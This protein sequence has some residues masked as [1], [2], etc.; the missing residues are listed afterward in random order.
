MPR[1]NVAAS[2]SFPVWI[3]VGIAGAILNAIAYQDWQPFVVVL[4]LYGAA[5]AVLY[6]TPLGGVVERRTFTAC[7]LTAWF[8]AGIAALYLQ[9]AQ[10][11]DQLND[12]EDFY[13]LASDP[14][15]APL[16]LA[17]FTQ[18][19][20]GAGA[21]VLWR[22][23]Y[24]F[25]A[26]LGLE[27]GRY[28]GITLNSLAVA[29]NGVVA[30]KICVEL[31]GYDQR[32]LRRLTVLLATCGLYGLFASIHLRDALVLLSVTVLTYVWVRFLRRSGVGNGV[33]VATATVLGLV[34]FPLLRGQF[35]FVPIATTLAGITAV[36][37]FDPPASR[38][39]VAFVGVALFGIV[40][41]VNLLIRYQ[42]DLLWVLTVTPQQYAE[43]AARVQGSLGYALIVGAPFPLNIVLKSVYQFVAPIP[44]WTGFQLQSAYLLFK[45]VAAVYFYFTIPLVVLAIVR[46]VR[47]KSWRTPA[48]MFLAIV[49][50]GFAVAVGATSGENR[51]IGAFLVSYQVLAVLPDLRTRSDL[52]FYKRWG[53]M[54]MAAIVAVHLAWAILKFL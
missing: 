23:V 18:L 29:L 10:D 19:T 20:G 50:I 28:V 22:S 32:R 41:F 8:T 7:F 36:L 17:T 47:N 37:I 9:F 3:C 4:G 53:G 26:S 5:Y 31:F 51:H 6:F 27:R 34:V 52:N 33:L 44:V 2:V 40:V 46:L 35:F 49:L 24:D 30:A 25:L 39:R 42:H 13:F 16:G 11:P 48:T 38:R 15:A 43:G 12:A 1:P 21:V 14:A 54:L 45:S